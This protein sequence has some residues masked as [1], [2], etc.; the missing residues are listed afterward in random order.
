MFSILLLPTRYHK[1][2]INKSY[3]IRFTLLYSFILDLYTPDFWGNFGSTYSTPLVQV[4]SPRGVGSVYFEKP[5]GSPGYREPVPILQLASPKSPY[6]SSRLS[7]N[8]DRLASLENLVPK[9]LGESSDMGDLLEGEVMS[10]SAHHCDTRRNQDT[11]TNLMEGTSPRAK[12]LAE[13]T[14][15]DSEEKW[16]SRGSVKDRNVSGNSSTDRSTKQGDANSPALHQTN[17]NNTTPPKTRMDIY[18]F[19]HPDHYIE[20]AHNTPLRNNSLS[21][22]GRGMLSNLTFHCKNRGKDQ[23]VPH[24]S[25]DS[26]CK[27][28][29][30]PETERSKDEAK[31]NIPCNDL[32]ICTD[33]TRYLHSD[34]EVMEPLSMTVG[35][36]YPGFPFSPAFSKQSSNSSACSSCV[37]SPV[38]LQNDSQC[39]TYSA[40]RYV[41]NNSDP[42]LPVDAEGKNLY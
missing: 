18:N 31:E 14:T 20:V 38:V 10:D 25:S 35:R 23:Q 21:N 30:P 1:N 22:E 39:F 7:A 6:A 24:S 40:R 5:C 32:Q 27:E 3:I 17:R 26:D 9:P 19:S 41:E 16:P 12:P 15:S 36:N 11:E 33:N 4:C 37:S 2:E 28:I 42:N 29:F 8:T 34:G 13:G